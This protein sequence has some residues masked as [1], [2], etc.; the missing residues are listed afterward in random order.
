[1]ALIL[2]IEDEQVLASNLCEAMKLSGHEARATHT[3][4]EGL[5]VAGSWMPDLVL[6]D[7]RLPGIDGLDVL[8]ELK[9]DGCPASVIMMTA[10]GNIASAVAAIR[11]GAADYL[12]KPLNLAE[13]GLVV[14]RV[15]AGRRVARHLEFF[16]QRELAGSACESIVGECPGMTEVKRFV[17]RITSSPALSSEEPPGVL[18]T[19][20]TGTGK[21]LVAR[22][23]HYAGPRR[24]KPFVHVNCT[25]LP[26]QLMESELFGH[27]RGAFTDAR[28]PKEGL[29]ACADGGT[30][31]LDEIGHMPTSMQAK[32]LAVLEHRRIRPVGA[33]AERAIDVHVIAATNRE[34]EPAIAAGEFR[35][36]LYHRLRVLRV[37]LPPLRERGPDILVLAEHFLGRHAARFGMDIEGFSPD[38]CAAFGSYRWPGNVRE[39]SHVV[40]SALLVSPGP[41]IR[42]A[43][44]NLRLPATAASA[45]LELNLG[46]ARRLSIDFANGCPTFEQIEHEVI[47]SA[48]A[49]TNQN[50]SHAAR[51][52]GL[53][54]DAVRYR[55]ERFAASAGPQACAP[56]GG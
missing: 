50:L 4:E 37:H 10:H 11:A 13:L 40:E 45:S 48:M 42:T 51:L 36:D 38:A 35:E 43:D 20:E 34:L 56:A 21:D 22:A 52:L 1:M 18:I 28:Q 8:R 55:L 46:A 5:K 19:G 49:F 23:I 2:V 7:L 31:F 39:L 17:H 24:E 14:A 16:R 12:T 44:L 9:S 47:T 32:L 3:G 41:V 26:E 54:R 25:A 27:V 29:L 30:V 53:S 33:T 15:L 6:C